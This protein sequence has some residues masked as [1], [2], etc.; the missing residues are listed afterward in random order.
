[1]NRVL[2]VRALV[3][4][5]SVMF[6]LSTAAQGQQIYQGIAQPGAGPI[7]TEEPCIL[8]PCLLYAG[9]FDPAGQNPDAL[10]NNN[11]LVFGIVGTVY[12]PFT[13][14]KK[15]KGAKG[16]TDWNVQ[17]LFM[18]ELMGD[19]GFGIVVES[20]SWSIV[21]G[22]ADGGNPSGGQ[23]KTICSG[24]GTPTLTPTGRASFGLVE[25]TI[26]ITGISCPTLEA[27]SY[28]MTMVPTTLGLAY[29]T[30]VEDNSPK[31]IEG[32]GSEPADLSF[33]F[34]PSF[35]FNSFSNT[36]TVCGNIGCDSFSVGVI[37]TAIH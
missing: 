25:E 27:G 4:A 1:M 3:I 2:G 34:S 29:L 11:S 19:V 9:D 18:N 30:D 31:N 15:F 7:G 37:G 22:V 23:V 33:F 6:C 13:I 17:G 26:L 21:Q 20:V 12:V 36:S 24:T 35:G 8:N 32:P 16:K 14:P 5:L 28:W 10:W